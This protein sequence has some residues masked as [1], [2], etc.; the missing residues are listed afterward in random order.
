LY[1]NDPPAGPGVRL[2]TFSLGSVSG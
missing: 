2:G 1:L